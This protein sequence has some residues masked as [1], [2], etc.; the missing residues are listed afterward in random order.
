MLAAPSNNSAIDQDLNAPLDAGDSAVNSDGA[1]ASGTA[2]TSGSATAGSASK[3]DDAESNAAAASERATAD[4]A[5]AARSTSDD[6]P[7]NAANKKGLVLPANDF[8]PENGVLR[9]STSFEQS[10]SP[11]LQGSLQTLPQGTKVTMIAQCNLNSEFSQKGDEVTFRIAQDVKD[12]K[13]GRVY[14]PGDWVA[15]GF[16]TDSVKEGRNGT[17]GRIEVKIDKIMSPDGQY[18]L[19]FECKISSADNKLL[20]VSKLVYRDA[21]FVTIGAGAG[22]ILAYQLG[23]LHLAISSYGGSI[24]VG[25]AVGATIGAVSAAWRKGNIASLY[26]NDELKLVT[27]EPIAIPGFNPA[28]LP[29]AAKK[30]TLD[31]LRV[32]VS[33]HNFEKD[34]VTGDKSAR[35]LY[36]TFN[37][38]NNSDKPIEKDM[39]RV[40]SSKGIRYHLDTRSIFHKFSV[41]PKTEKTDRFCF[42]VDSPKNKYYLILVDHKNDEFSRVPIN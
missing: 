27:G 23:G 21:K 9:G 28:N 36:V 31:G 18:E 4:D 16:V 2:V 29:S 30:K 24:A 35:L 42:N 7:V 15:H 22:A 1:D 34:T 6:A 37:V 12:D 13:S 5:P 20:A 41:P 26:P 33:Q 38:V 3:P 14:L 8:L 17:P 39:L 11:I 40:V 25:A 19:P 32:S 10:S